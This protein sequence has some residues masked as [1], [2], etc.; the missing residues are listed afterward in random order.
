VRIFARKTRRSDVRRPPAGLGKG[1]APERRVPAS[2][3]LVG[4]LFIIATS[5]VI[6]IGGEVPRWQFGQKPQHDIRARV[7]FQELDEQATE[8]ERRNKELST[9]NYY[10]VNDAFFKKIHQDFSQFY[11]TVKDQE[12]FDQLSEAK[13]EWLA[14]PWKVD[15]QNFAKIREQIQKLQAEDVLNAVR[16]ELVKCPIIQEMPEAYRKAT[17]VILTDPQAGSEQETK[18]W[19]FAQDGTRVAEA[20]S[21]AAA[22][23]PPPLGEAIHNYLTERFQPIWVF[24]RE[25]TNQQ[26][27]ARSE[28][29]ENEQYRKYERD[30]V[31]VRQGQTIVG[32][33]LALLKLEHQTYLN[34]LSSRAKLAAHASVGVLVL[35]LTVFLG[36][37][38]AN[39]EFRAVHNWSR[40]LAV[41][42]LLFLVVALARLLDLL[43]WNPHTSVFGMVLAASIVTIAYN[44]RF[45]LV[46]S[47]A[48]VGL[49]LVCLQGDYQLFLPL[50]AAAA[51]VIFTLD[52]VRSRSKLIEVAGASAFI[53]FAVVW[54]AQL[55]SFQD[56][57]YAFWTSI[58]AAL[59][60]LAAGLV[61]QGV[62]P[63]IER[64]FQ[65]ATSM[66]LL[67]WCDA[68]KPLLRRLALEAPGTFSHSLLIGSLAESA[69][70]AIGANGLLARV[71]AYYHDVGKICKPDYFVENQ[72]NVDFTRHKGL[73][74]AMSLLV[75]IGHVKD[76]LQLAREYGLPKVLHQF[77]VEH[78]GTTLVE[79]FYHL[80]ARKRE[81]AG[82]RPASDV[83]F[84]YPGPKPHAKE[85]AI[86]MLA[87]SAEGAARALS[88][89]SVGGIEAAVH[90]VVKKKLED[91]Q[92]DE[93]ELTLR[94]IHLVE[95]ALIKTL[96]AIHHG[97]VKYPN[98]PGEPEP[99]ADEAEP[100]SAER[101]AGPKSKLTRAET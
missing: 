82:E 69:A 19:A 79:Y 83:D 13:K 90:Q 9:P 59:A 53:G 74:P 17:L 80:E 57:T 38:A 29:K 95:E 28:A 85:S 101:K 3:Y 66:T 76:G 68:S 35:L 49:L 36:V 22:K 81:E 54:A 52:E 42:F 88:E 84:R 73:S 37:Y 50:T 39:F 97:R 20:V 23:V 32:R 7:E 1:E 6:G 14:K 31:L 2:V 24:D 8:R 27:K 26:R 12:S 64:L 25:M 4:F 15:E 94:E 21:Q 99:S 61:V 16:A 41:A 67:E 46:V 92:L 70:E 87:D 89:P 40:F 56:F 71:G 55:A 18:S 65:I 30:Q 33:E 11:I 58:T 86:L 63:L 45:A 98:R 60:A 78:H 47:T 93:S 44:Q 72:P 51:T 62:L 91:G 75:I 34:S 10:R 48:L 77:I 5:L 43:G 96:W 100:A